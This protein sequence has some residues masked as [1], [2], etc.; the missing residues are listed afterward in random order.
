MD[1]SLST[2]QGNAHTCPAHHH[3]SSH[4]H[5]TM[6]QDQAHP[7]KAMKALPYMERRERNPLRPPTTQRDRRPHPW[8][9]QHPTHPRP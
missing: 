2:I 9:S 3:Q 4:Q 5:M 6:S 8:T 7:P 1:L